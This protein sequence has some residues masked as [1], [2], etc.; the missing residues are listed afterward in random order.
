MLSGSRMSVRTASATPPSIA[1]ATEWIVP[2]RRLSCTS[3]VRA[4]TTTL[5]PSRARGRAIYSLTPRLAP[6]TI[7]TF[8][9]SCPATSPPL[10]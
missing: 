3:S 4:A 9:S 8:P 2:G 7:A 1:S 6:V 10:L 5:T